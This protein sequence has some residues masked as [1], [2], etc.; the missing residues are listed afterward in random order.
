VCRALHVSGTEDL[1]LYLAS[2]DDERQFAFHVLEIIS[3][4]FREQVTISSV[5]WMYLIASVN[6]LLPT[7]R[8]AA[9]IGRSVASVTLC[10]FLF[11]CPC[12]WAISCRHTDTQVTDISDHPT[13]AL[14]TVS[15]GNFSRWT[16]SLSFSSVFFLVWSVKEPFGIS[17]MGIFVGWSGDNTSCRPT[18]SFKALQETCWPCFILVLFTIKLVGLVTEMALF[19]YMAVFR[20]GFVKIQVLS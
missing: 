5:R 7:H 15:F 3:L 20:E 9:W 11:V 4:M 14:A 2:S 13:H 18:I 1:L 19:P 8:Q 12:S 6:N 16:W 17:Y 10:V